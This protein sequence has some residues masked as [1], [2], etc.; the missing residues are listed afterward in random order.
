VDVLLVGFI[1][2]GAWPCLVAVRKLRVAREA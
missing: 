2:L 1:M